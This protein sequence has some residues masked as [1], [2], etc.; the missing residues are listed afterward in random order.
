M[1]LFIVDILFTCTNSFSCGFAFAL[2]MAFFGE[3]RQ[4]TRTIVALDR[5]LS[6]PFFSSFFLVLGFS[7][8][9]C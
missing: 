8:W 9:V 5:R 4:K 3:G 7:S 2:G 1:S 6:L